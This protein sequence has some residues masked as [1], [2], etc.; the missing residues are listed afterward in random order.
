VKK[1]SI[2]RTVSRIL[3]GY[4]ALI[5]AAVT[6]FGVW[7]LAGAWGCTPDCGAGAAFLGLLGFAWVTQALVAGVVVVILFVLTTRWASPGAAV[8]N[9]VA[10]GLL[11]LP[12]LRFLELMGPFGLP[13]PG[14]YALGVAIGAAVI[15]VT[16]GILELF[17]SDRWL[18]PHRSITVTCLVVIP[19]AAASLPVL[20]SVYSSAQ[21]GSD[22]F[23]IGPVTAQ[24]VRDHGS[25]LP[26]AYPG[27]RVT[28]TSAS[29]ESKTFN[30]YRMASWEERL[31]NNRLKADV[32]GW[33]QTSLGDA[34]WRRVVCRPGGCPDDF[35]LVLVRGSRECLSV[36]VTIDG[37]GEIV[38]DYQITPSAKPLSGDPT[39]DHRYCTGQY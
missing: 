15:I 22:G 38:I 11:L 9:I 17:V 20:A 21:I 8:A 6:A 30:R 34:G 18:T 33:Y 35:V 14:R 16:L 2:W 1:R 10:E 37:A 31:T 27:S 29:A 28:Y 4:Q 7:I 3:L 39:A 23:P 19:F 36:L 26:L 12:A 5:A 24:F 32:E 13:G 25:K